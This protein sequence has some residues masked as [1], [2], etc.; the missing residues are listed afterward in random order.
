MSYI[1]EKLVYPGLGLVRKDGFVI[2]VRDVL[3]GERISLNIVRKKA[4]YAE[5]Q[6][7]EIHEPSPD[8]IQPRCPHFGQCGG[9]QLQHAH[10]CIHSS[11]KKAWLQE[12]LRGREPDDFV[13]ASSFFE[14]RKKI[15]LHVL[16]RQLGFFSYDNRTLVPITCC[17]IFSADEDLFQRFKGIA[18]SLPDR[19]D[20][21]LFR[22]PDLRIL[23]SGNIDSELRNEIEA[24]S[25]LGREYQFQACG[26]Q[27][28]ASTDA[29]VQ[30]HPTVEAMWN[31]VVSYIK[32]KNIKRIFD[33]Y[34]GVGVT[35]VLLAE[36][37]I[38]VEAI[39]GS[40]V[41][42]QAAEKNKCENVQFYCGMVEKVLLTLKRGVD[43]IVVNPPRTGLSK[44]VRK[45]CVEHDPTYIIY[46]SCSPATLA[47]DMQ[48]FEKWNIVSL[49]GYDLF[50][51]TGHFETVAIFEKP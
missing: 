44:N 9:C 47:R 13:E 49:K 6:L 25:V 26:R 18:R 15:T 39:E 29:F 50:P 43:C 32:M 20:I 33:L 46:I 14:W 24:L 21:S 5:G 30:N 17:P 10:P 31:D 12:V 23:V 2:F 11:L 27:W 45:A 4:H 22:T 3:P 34:A 42:V 16:S 37:G 41:A 1:V 38:C 7:V 36:Q 19:V 48:S 51:Q 28:W 8:R 40:K 35:A